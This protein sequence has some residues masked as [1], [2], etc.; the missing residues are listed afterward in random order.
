ML[1]FNNSLSKSLGSQVEAMIA[2]EEDTDQGRQDSGG[3]E[4]GDELLALKRPQQEAE[5]KQK[6]TEGDEID[7]ESTPPREF[8]SSEVSSDGS[9]DIGDENNF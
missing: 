6:P 4:Y 3:R 1:K 9:H 5:S 2:E 7:D 8:G